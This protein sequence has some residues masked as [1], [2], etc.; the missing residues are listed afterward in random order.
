MDDHSVK[1]QKR[2]KGESFIVTDRNY[3]DKLIAEKSKKSKKI[4]A[5][6]SNKIIVKSNIPVINKYKVIKSLKR[7]I[8]DDDYHTNIK[9]KPLA[10]I[11]N[12]SNINIDNIPIMFED[13]TIVQNINH[14][15]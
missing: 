8:S 2:I 3:I 14:C 5:E 13:G 7:K 1:I 12:V 4:E 11:T 10:E 6:E 9:R 15:K